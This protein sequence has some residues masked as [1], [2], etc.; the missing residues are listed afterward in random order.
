MAIRS[1]RAGKN[2]VDAVSHPDLHISIRCVYRPLLLDRCNS[3]FQLALG[4][5]VTASHA[6]Q[7]A[8]GR[9]SL[10]CCCH[11]QRRRACKIGRK[12]RGFEQSQFDAKGFDLLRQTFL[13]RFDCPFGGAIEADKGTATIP[14]PLETPM[15]GPLS[16]CRSKGSAA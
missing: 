8:R 1:N 7:V 9:P 5:V 4:G 16:Y 14:M 2:S 11:L 15:M 10:D 3:I 12:S 13:E 6:S